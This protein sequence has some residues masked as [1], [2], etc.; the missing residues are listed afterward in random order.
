M[1][2]G[3]KTELIKGLMKE[4]CCPLSYTKFLMFNLRHHITKVKNRIESFTIED[5]EENQIVRY[6]AIVERTL[7]AVENDIKE[8][9]RRQKNLEKAVQEGR[10]SLTPRTRKTK[11]V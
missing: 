10:L 3:E 9:R 6:L 2:D 1:D 5:K 11:E 8:K 7:S 4:F